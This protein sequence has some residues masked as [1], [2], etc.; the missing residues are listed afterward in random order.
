M[1][2]ILWEFHAKRGAE[3]EFE[4]AYGAQGDWVE[5]FKHGKGYLSTEFLRDPARP[6]RY[7]TIDRWTSQ[8]DYEA[9][10]RARADEYSALDQRCEQLTERELLLGNWL[11]L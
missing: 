6:G 7:L 8:E 5:F 10:R 11:S 2:V 9:F 1:Y 4:Q 3:Q